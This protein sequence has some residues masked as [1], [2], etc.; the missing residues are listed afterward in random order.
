MCFRQ[1]RYGRFWAVYEDDTL[2]CV[3]VYKKG[4]L[5]VIRRLAKAEGTVRTETA[6]T[7]IL[8]PDHPVI[9]Q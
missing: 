4:A 1:E 6:P 8:P 9:P 5:A 2:I 3:T 7:L